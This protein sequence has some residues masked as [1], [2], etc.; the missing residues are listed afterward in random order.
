MGNTSHSILCT[1]RWILIL[2]V[3]ATSSLCY[4]EIHGN[5][6]I[7][8]WHIT[9]VQ[10]LSATCHI[11][12]RFFLL[13]CDMYYVYCIPYILIVCITSSLLC[14]LAVWKWQHILK[15]EVMSST[16]PCVG[17]YVIKKKILQKSSGCRDDG[18]NKHRSKARRA[19]AQCGPVSCHFITVAKNVLW[20]KV[21]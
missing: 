5:I 14:T 3:V 18:L 7:C 13:S 17:T 11:N 8:V 4:C 20:L 12:N 6:T 19:D 10:K 15:S 9:R 16:S 21:M 1:F 2:C